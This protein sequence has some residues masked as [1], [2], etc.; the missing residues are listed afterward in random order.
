MFWLI[1]KVI[2]TIVGVFSALTYISDLVS[3]VNSQNLSQKEHDRHAAL[4][5]ILTIII[6]IVWSIIVYF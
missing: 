2:L 6:S 1:C 3:E 5:F 4:R